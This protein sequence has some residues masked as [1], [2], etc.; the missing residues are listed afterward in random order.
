MVL[1]FELRQVASTCIRYQKECFA[2]YFL[3]QL[4]P[5]NYDVPEGLL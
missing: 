2:F 3:S 4:I 5:T 1:G